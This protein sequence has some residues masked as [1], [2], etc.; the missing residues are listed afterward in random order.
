[1]KRKEL[2]KAFM[3]ISDNEKPLPSAWFIQ[4][5]L[6]V[7]RVNTLSAEIQQGRD[8]KYMVIEP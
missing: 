5:Y 3:M 4:K 1:M 2:T 7:I 6:S 8:Y